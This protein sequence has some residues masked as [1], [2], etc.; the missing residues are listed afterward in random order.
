MGIGANC[1]IRNA[2]IDKDCRIGDYVSIHG[3]IALPDSD[4]DTYSIRE[5][6]IVVR[7]GAHI[8]SNTRIGLGA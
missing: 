8:P 5:G 4:T 2:I 3:S 1:N 7:K 6:I